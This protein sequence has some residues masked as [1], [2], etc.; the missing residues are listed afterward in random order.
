MENLKFNNQHVAVQMQLQ[1]S[2]EIQGVPNIAEVAVNKRL[3]DF[4][5]NNHVD[6]WLNIELSPDN[7]NTYFQLGARGIALGSKDSPVLATASQ[8]ANPST[9]QYFA[10]QN[11]F[12][13][14]LIAKT[15]DKLENHELFTGDKYVLFEDCFKEG[16]SWKIR[17]VIKVLAKGYERPVV[18]Q[19]FGKEL[20]DILG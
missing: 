20:S 11:S 17:V 12:I 6:F 19:D 9:V 7:G 18:N 10:R 1:P 8:N 14:S 13:K 3:S 2:L 16:T 5:E 4:T 15:C